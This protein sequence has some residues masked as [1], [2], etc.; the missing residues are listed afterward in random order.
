MIVESVNLPALWAQDSF[1]V[2]RL[3]EQHFN[4]L[5]YHTSPLEGI[6]RNRIKMAE[7]R[8]LKQH[9]L[10]LCVALGSVVSLLV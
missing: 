3:T 1:R 7:K 10:V 5:I 2:V 9:R 6:Q 4:L 8:L